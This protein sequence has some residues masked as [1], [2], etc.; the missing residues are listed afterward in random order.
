M[1]FGVIQAIV[2]RNV[3][4]MF[5]M[6]ADSLQAFVPDAGL[7]I[8]CVGYKYKNL[9]FVCALLLFLFLISGFTDG[10][11]KIVCIDM[12]RTENIQLIF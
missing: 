7:N 2:K 11:L 8:G 5:V 4:I 3:R 9:P 12:Q 1:A 6:E 10:I